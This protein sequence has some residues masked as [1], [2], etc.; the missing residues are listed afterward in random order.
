MDITGVVTQYDIVYRPGYYKNMADALSRVCSSS[1]TNNSDKLYQ[2]YDALTLR[3][4]QN[5][6]L[7]EE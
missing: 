3:N 6:S 4:N 5:G 1:L 2:T 7:G